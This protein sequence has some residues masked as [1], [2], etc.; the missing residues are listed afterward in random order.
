LHRYK[1]KNEAGGSY[2]MNG[3]LGLMS[4][5]MAQQLAIVGGGYR[6]KKPIS[7]RNLTVSNCGAAALLDFGPF[8]HFSLYV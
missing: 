1:S 2:Y 3:E 7:G 5:G 4:A 8:F 6:A